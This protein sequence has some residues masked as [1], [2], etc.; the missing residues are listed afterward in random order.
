MELA[1]LIICACSDKRKQ[2]KA[3]AAWV[4]SERW[5]W[6]MRTEQQ[7]KS[8]N[9]SRKTLSSREVFIVFLFS[10]VWRQLKQ[11]SKLMGEA[12]RTK[13]L[14]T[15]ENKKWP[16]SFEGK[17]DPRYTGIVDLG[18]EWVHLFFW[19][20]KVNNNFGNVPI[21]FNEVS[22]HNAYIHISIYIYICIFLTVL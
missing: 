13:N 4:I 22:E 18:K 16:G 17:V 6:A 5:R 21:C 8:G 14:M 9:N 19:G 12:N 7:Q 2:S 11:L 3:A 1:V 20:G 10:F 15:E